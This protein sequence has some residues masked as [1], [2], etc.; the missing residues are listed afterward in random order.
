MNHEHA[1]ELADWITR[2]TKGFANRNGERIYIEGTIDAF[3]LLLYAQSLLTPTDT[4]AIY[5]ANEKK[6]KGHIIP[7]ADQYGD[8]GMYIPG[9]GFFEF[10]RKL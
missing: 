5:D 8:L 1:T 4:K 7:C 6:Y 2:N 3:E 10:K 9:E